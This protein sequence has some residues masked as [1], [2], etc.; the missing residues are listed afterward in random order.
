VPRSDE[1]IF[2]KQA[3]A[4]PGIDPVG[5]IVIVGDDCC[6]AILA[7]GTYKTIDLGKVVFENVLASAAKA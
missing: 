7:T 4:F 2:F 3:L 1:L 6:F 5:R